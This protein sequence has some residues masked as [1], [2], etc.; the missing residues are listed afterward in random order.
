MRCRATVQAAVLAVL[1]LG[2]LVPVASAADTE[3]FFLGPEGIPL[4]SLNGT[5]HGGEMPNYDRGRDLEL[6]LLLVRSDNGLA[7][8]DETRYQHWQAEMTGRH[9]VG[10]PTLVVWS[11]A[12][13]FES[14]L[15]SVFTIYLLDCPK[16]A[17]ACQELTSQEVTVE[18]EQSGGWVETEVFLP[19]IDHGF[20]D[21]RHLGVRIVVSE[22]SE[23]DM[24]FAYGYPKYRS[25]LTISPDAP[26]AL[27]EATLAPPAQ[28]PAL[29]SIER[30]ERVKPLS[31]VTVEVRGA[32]NIGSLTP[33]LATLTASTVLL[34]ALGVILVF[35]LSPHGRRERSKSDTHGSHGRNRTVISS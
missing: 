26:P 12:A 13:G 8:T 3:T 17:F 35:T 21:G 16:S 6:G 32:G 22:S 29:A 19:P 34:V 28:S 31:P 25:R 4:G 14:Q 11:A 10:Y 24:M 5:P 20:D 9:L 33:W 27:A 2:V 7:E 18:P 30:L 15:A 23:T 1:S